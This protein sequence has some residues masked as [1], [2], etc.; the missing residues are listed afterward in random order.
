MTAPDKMPP[1][2]PGP[3]ITT[4]DSKAES[5]L[6]HIYWNHHDGLAAACRAQHGC[7][8]LAPANVTCIKCIE[9]LKENGELK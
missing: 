3:L 5:Q 2:A 8:T 4:S 9:V 1:L 6:W 7:F